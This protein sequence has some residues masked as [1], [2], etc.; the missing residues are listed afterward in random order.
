MEGDR[1]VG[2]QENRGRRGMG[3]KREK[4]GGKWEKNAKCYLLSCI[5]ELE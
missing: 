1:G 2:A 3:G 5:N 4:G